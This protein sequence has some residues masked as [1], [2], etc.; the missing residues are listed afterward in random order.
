M[1]KKPHVV[2]IEEVSR[3]RVIIWADDV[4]EAEEIADELC[5]DGEINLDYDD[6]QERSCNFQ[7]IANASDVSL[8]AKYDRDGL[9]LKEGATIN[10]VTELP[11]TT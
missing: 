1:S 3:R 7:R 9:V 6:F 2:T 10:C 5:S 8:L 11:V 4:S